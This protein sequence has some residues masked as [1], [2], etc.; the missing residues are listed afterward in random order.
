MIRQEEQGWDFVDDGLNVCTNCF[1]DEAIKRFIE[2]NASE[3]ECSYCEACSEE[4]IAAS[5]NSVLEVIGSA[6][7][8]GYEDPANSLPVEGGEYVFSTMDIDDVLDEI[9]WPTQSDSVADEIREAFSGRAWVQKNFFGLP[10]D[11]QLRY[12][13]DDFVEAVKYRTRYLFAMPFTDES[14]LG[15]DDIPPHKMLEK[16]GNVIDNVGLIREVKAGTKWLRARIHDPRESYSTASELG[17]VPRD[18]AVYSNRMSPAGIPMFYGAMNEVTAIAETY[19]PKAE[20]K[21]VATVATFKTAHD[22]DMLDLTN[23][24]TMPSAFDEDSR[25]LR[26]AIGFLEDFVEE[27]TRPITKDGREHIEYVPTQIV[28]EYFRHVFKTPSGKPVRGILYH[29]SHIDEGICCVLF[30]ENENCCET[31]PGWKVDEKNCLGLIGII[32]KVL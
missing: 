1:D 29:S 10:E 18:K 8:H 23:L 6:V 32:R 22:M 12:G 28:T 9:G 14:Q 26:P 20:R 7:E 31:T 24:P 13:W 16:I 21:A 25:H 11:D 19:L 30:L 3:K 5:M 4:P 17:T 15:L 27:L 2:E